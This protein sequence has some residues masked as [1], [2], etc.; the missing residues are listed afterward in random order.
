MRRN[1][2][3]LAGLALTL[4]A[5]SQ[6]DRAV[7]GFEAGPGGWHVTSAHTTMTS[8]IQYLGASAD[9]AIIVRMADGTAQ[10]WAPNR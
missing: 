6:I 2:L 3:L 8:D 7:R 1:V 9:G 4:G 5:C 10:I